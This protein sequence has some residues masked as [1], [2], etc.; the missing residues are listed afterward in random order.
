MRCG[1]NFAQNQQSTRSQHMCR[2][3]SKKRGKNMREM[4]RAINTTK[5]GRAPQQEIGMP[6]RILQNIKQKVCQTC[7]K[8]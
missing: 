8:T 5:E 4:A 6:C 1:S 2:S 3:T 7:L